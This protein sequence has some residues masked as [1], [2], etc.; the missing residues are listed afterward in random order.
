MK[1]SN[2][3][4]WSSNGEHG[5]ETVNL[6]V[7]VVAVDKGIVPIFQWLNSKMEIFTVWS[8]QGEKDWYCEE[9][10]ANTVVYAYVAFLSRNK[11]SVEEIKKCSTLFKTKFP[12]SEIALEYEHDMWNLWLHPDYL[13]RFVDHIKEFEDANESVGCTGSLDDPKNEGS[14]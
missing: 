3:N 2:E 6:P 5:H 11:E 1:A 4:F 10:R 14:V 7:K 9:M 13:T 12:E 8:C